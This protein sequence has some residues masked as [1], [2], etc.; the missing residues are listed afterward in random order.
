M[1]TEREFRELLRKAKRDPRTW[2]LQFQLWIVTRKIRH[3]RTE[4]G[5]HGRGIR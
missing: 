1:Q 4:K 3:D 5:K 2:W